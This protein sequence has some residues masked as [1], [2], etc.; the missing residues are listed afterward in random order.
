MA[1]MSIRPASNMILLSTLI[2]SILLIPM[3][4]D[5]HVAIALTHTGPVP[6]PQNLIPHPG[7]S[8]H[9]HIVKHHTGPV[10]IPQNL[11]PH[12]G[13]SNHNHIVKHH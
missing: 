1:V 8:N 9:N 13:T 5:L 2:F 12:P 4:T 10:P 6:I 3:M 11:I 7:T